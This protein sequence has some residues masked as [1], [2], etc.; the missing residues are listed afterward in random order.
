MKR[1]LTTMVLQTM[2]TH[3]LGRV[4][5]VEQ[6]SSQNESP[7]TPTCRLVISGTPHAL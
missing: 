6:T 5:L 3:A 1:L 4:T 7:L 2:G